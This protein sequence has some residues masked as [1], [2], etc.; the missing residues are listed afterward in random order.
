MK[1]TLL[2]F[3]RLACVLKRGITAV[4]CWN[5]N[6]II[7]TTVQTSATPV[8]SNKTTINRKLNLGD[9]ATLCQIC[10]NDGRISVQLYGRINL[11]EITDGSTTWAEI[12]KQNSISPIKTAN[13]NTL[14]DINGVIES[15]LLTTKHKMLYSTHKSIKSMNA[16]HARQTLTI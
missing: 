9:A 16:Q 8:N 4:F 13:N 14:G 10:H 11:T 2:L 3:T 15:L 12:N 7:R 1:K 6:A 5:V